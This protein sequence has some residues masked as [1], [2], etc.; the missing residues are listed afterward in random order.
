M[1]KSSKNDF[2]NRRQAFKINNLSDL[3][4]QFPMSLTVP[5]SYVHSFSTF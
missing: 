5:Q 3:Q 1:D 4:N 2:V